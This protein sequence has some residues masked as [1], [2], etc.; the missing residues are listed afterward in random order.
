MDEAKALKMYR[1]P[2]CEL[3]PP[4]RFLLCMAGV[5]RLV[6]KVRRGG[7]TYT[8]GGGGAAGA[9]VRRSLGSRGRRARKVPPSTQTE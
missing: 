3:S 1:G 7:S 2:P 6:G 5:P 9:G 4:E 8:P